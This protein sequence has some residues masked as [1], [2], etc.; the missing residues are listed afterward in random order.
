MVLERNSLGLSEVH[1]AEPQ[2]EERCRQH[3]R[4][5]SPETDT[6]R[7]PDEVEQVRFQSG[8]RAHENAWSKQILQ[9]LVVN[10]KVMEVPPRIV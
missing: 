2:A 1:N 5:R 9:Y 8:R 7:S 6:S 10:P 4:D 3:V